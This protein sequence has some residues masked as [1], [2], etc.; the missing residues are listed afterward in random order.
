M[1]P[2]RLALSLARPQR[3]TSVLQVFANITSL[4]D[5]NVYKLGDSVRDSDA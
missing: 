4:K 1:S 2:L 5:C 3:S